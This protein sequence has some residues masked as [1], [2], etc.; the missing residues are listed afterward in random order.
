MNGIDDITPG[1]ARLHS[2][3]KLRSVHIGDI[4]VSYVHDGWVQLAPTSWLPD[5]S[6]EYWA[7]HT[8]YLDDEGYLRAG[9]GGVLAETPD[10]TV[11]IDAGFG[12]RRIP[13]DPAVPRLG[14]TTGGSL[15]ASLAA[16]GV[17]P[18]QV[19][20]LAFTHLHLDHIGW[21]SA[22]DPA[23]G[24]TPF[25]HARA[26]TTAAEWN[27]GTSDVHGPFEETM[28]MLR[29][30]LELVEDAS[31]FFPGITLI[32]APGH[33]AGHAVYEI[34]SKGRRVIAFGDLFHSPVQ[35][36]NPH[37]SAQPDLDTVLST[38]SRHAILQHLVQ[39][40]TLGF[41]IHFADVTFGRVVVSEQGS[42]RWQP[43]ATQVVDAI[44]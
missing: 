12:P 42:H 36:E 39:D 2:T 26:V 28:R 21:V 40:N 19:D 35:I 14:A 10:G 8:R 6:A 4:R 1:E 34:A 24:H 44:R 3:P 5:S 25:A 20:V 30:R 41:G 16:L 29:P 37:W 23:T 13:A 18:D 43:V 32:F 7:Q 27:H 15:L 33:S 22:R 38:R 11:L 17:S 9:M 31:E